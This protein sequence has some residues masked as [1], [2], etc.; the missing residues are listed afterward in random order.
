MRQLKGYW[1]R[2]LSAI[3]IVTCVFHLYTGMFG[4][5][6]SLQQRAVHVGLVLVLV[7]LL[8][9]ARKSDDSKADIP[10]W[11]LLFIVLGLGTTGFIAVNFLTFMQ[12][13]IVHVTA[14][15]IT[16][17]IVGTL[18]I[19]ETGRRTVGWVFPLLTALAFMYVLWG[20]YIPGHFGHAYMARSMIFRELY[21]SADGLWGFVTGLSATYIALFIIF[22]ALLLHSGGGKT[23]IDLA[24]L[25]GGRFRGGAAKVAVLAS[26]FFAMIS[27][28]SSAN[29]ATTGSFTIPM[30]KKL[31]YSPE[32]AGGVESAA[33]TGGMLTP[34]VM[35]ATA[36]IMA[37]L[38]SVSYL[39]V[40]I[41]AVIPA[42]LYYFTIFMG[43]H[44]QSVKLNLK[45]VPREELPPWRSILTV[46]RMSGI[47][48]PIGVLL[49]TLFKG[50][51]LTFVGS[52]ACFSL[53]LIYILSGRSLRG[54][55]ERLRNIP[56]LLENGGKALVTIMPVLVCASMII[57]LLNFAGLD[58]KF[59][60]M[61]MSIGGANL[62]IGLLLT[63]V[64][65]MILGTGLPLTPAYMIGITVAGPMLINWG[66]LP[67]AAH[68]F[69]VYYGSLSNITPPVCTAV[70]VASSIAKADFLKIAWAAMRLAP[71]LYIVPF[72]FVWDNTFIMI[73]S[74]WSILLNVGTAMLGAALLSSSVMGYLVT[75]CKIWERLALAASGTLLLVPTWQTDLWGWV[76]GFAILAKE[77]V[78]RR[79]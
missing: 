14:I 40:V 70:F 50:Y 45:P 48:L 71:M 29:V 76:L 52:S 27:G 19:L 73:G 25:V 9:P 11:D 10:W 68:L 58:F 53:L 31:G 37:E 13:K 39:K 5:L 51:S 7:Y 56:S 32:F 8:Y 44:F 22:G 47:L 18:V 30:M 55:L 3:A 20:H 38:L 4:L 64:L 6:P 33:S 41:A 79:E 21:L 46:S 62:F 72:L 12:G 67:M 15:E 54:I 63:G 75:K 34:P 35:G 24:M 16:L 74:P 26:G 43:V 36:F 78:G 61:F 28:S 65:V 69:I 59:S 42:S 2:V 57:F 17:A 60:T 1:K 49:Y 66:I 23:F 77:L